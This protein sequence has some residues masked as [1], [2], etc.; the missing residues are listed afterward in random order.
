MLTSI[1]VEKT[2]VNTVM[3]GQWSVTFTLKGFDGAI[4]LFSQDFS[5]DYK[6]G[7]PISRV[8]AGFIGDMQNYIDDYKQEQVYMTHAQM[9][10]SVTVVQSGLVI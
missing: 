10:N 5:Q 2:S 3:E 1:T 6:T 7:D 9:D 8:Q 4:E